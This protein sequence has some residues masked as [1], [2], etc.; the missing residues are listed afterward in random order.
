[1][2]IQVNHEVLNSQLDL[3]GITSY[4]ILQFDKDDSFTGA[5]LSLGNTLGSFS[6]ISQARSYLI[7]PFDS[8]FPLASLEGFYLASDDSDDENSEEEGG[9]ELCPVCGGINNAGA[10]VFSCSHILALLWEGE[11]QWTEPEFDEII[12][13]T[14][15]ISS[16][17]QENEALEEEETGLYSMFSP[18]SY[19]RTNAI[20]ELFGESLL[21]GNPRH[22]DTYLSSGSG[23]LLYILDFKVLE[24][25][26]E[27]L[28]NFKIEV[29]NRL[30]RE[31]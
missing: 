14:D 28:R 18:Y 24:E 21:T 22:E 20:F 2:L 6:L 1:M 5:S 15:E 8:T 27:K 31:T 16:L 11:F 29:L 7:L 3:T 4:V 9:D 13:L 30:N 10:M 12:T 26:L 19:N 17:F 23:S 25:V